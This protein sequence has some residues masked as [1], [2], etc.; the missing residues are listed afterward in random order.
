[1]ETNRRIRSMTLGTVGVT[2]IVAVVVLLG[3]CSGPSGPGTDDSVPVASPDV[4]E[5]AEPLATATPTI[6]SVPPTLTLIPTPTAT[7]VPTPSPRPATATPT[8]TPAPEPTATPRPTPTPA[9]TPTPVP[10]AEPALSLRPPAPVCSTPWMSPSPPSN[11][12][13]SPRG[14]SSM[15]GWT[16]RP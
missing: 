13:G 6:I 16:R 8:P 15:I 12:P 3:A 4:V 1:M 9:P 7:P 10:T 5:T 14:R 11:T 2:L